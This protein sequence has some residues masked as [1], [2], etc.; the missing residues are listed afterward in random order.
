MCG[1]LESE[2]GLLFYA[3]CPE[4]SPAHLQQD[5]THLQQGPSL[6]LWLLRSPGLMQC[7]ALDGLVSDVPLVE[8]VDGAGENCTRDVDIHRTV[9]RHSSLTIIFH[10]YLNQEGSEAKSQQRESDGRDSLMV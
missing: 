4:D 9:Y 6:D 8:S 5:P 7:S 2:P 3:V 1:E 10:I